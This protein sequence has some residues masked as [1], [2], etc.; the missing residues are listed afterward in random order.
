MKGLLDSPLSA[1]PARVDREGERLYVFPGGQECCIDLTSGPP[2][3]RRMVMDELLMLLRNAGV[4]VESCRIE[5][6]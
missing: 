5:G 1:R 6:T 2:E 3:A 4:S